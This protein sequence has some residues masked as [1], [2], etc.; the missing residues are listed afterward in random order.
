MNRFLFW[1]IFFSTTFSFFSVIENLN[2]RTQEPLVSES[3]RSS[4]WS[5]E[6]SALLTTT[7]PVQISVA[8]RN[9]EGRGLI[10]CRN[11]QGFSTE[12][13]VTAKMKMK[14]DPTIKIPTDESY[15]A[16]SSQNFAVPRDLNHVFDHYQP[17]I[18]RPDVPPGKEGEVVQGRN[19]GNLI[20]LGFTGPRAMIKQAANAELQLSYDSSAPNFLQ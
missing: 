1:G 13:A 3:L 7:D 18:I 10:V 4:I 15:L 8:Y 6:L 16:L 11:Q 20:Q 2:A 9:L 5:C 14:N 19:Y 12:L 17:R